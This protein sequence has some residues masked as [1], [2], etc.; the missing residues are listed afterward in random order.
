MTKS[1]R[2]LIQSLLAL[3]VLILLSGLLGY[4]NVVQLQEDTRR[5]E[6]AH[7]VLGSLDRFL[8]ALLDA[9][10]GQRGFLLTGAYPY[11]DPYRT[12][13]GRV[14]AELLLLRGLV[15][16][17]ATQEAG[18]PTLELLVDSRLEEMQK[19]VDLNWLDPG[20]ARRVVDSHAGKNVMDAIRIQLA[21]LTD[22]E[23]ARLAE[24][25]RDFRRGLRVA[26]WSGTFLMLAALALAGGFILQL[27]R[28]LAARARAEQELERERRWLQVTLAS[29]GDAVITTDRA[30]RVSF[31]NPVAET[32]TGWTSGDAAGQPLEAVFHIIDEQ[33]RLPAANPVSRVL[34]EGVTVGLAHH[35]A[36]VQKGGREL[37]IE[38]SAAPIQGLGEETAGV[39]LVFHDVT[40]ARRADAER[41]Q[42]EAQLFQSQRLESLAHLAGGVAHDINNVL[43]AILSLAS[44]RR[45]Q[46]DPAGDLAQALG[47]I[48]T[49][50]VRGRDVVKGLLYFA[51]KGM[52]TRGP[53]DLNALVRQLVR[54]LDATT[55]KQVQLSAELQEPLPL[56]QGDEAALSHALINV[57]MNALDAMP[58]GGALVIGTRAT[59]DGGVEVRV[60]D[61]GGGMSP[62][63]L[64]QAIDPFFTTKPVGK[65]TGLGLSMVYGTMKAHGGTVAIHSEPGRG[66]EVRLGFPAA[67]GLAQVPAGTE[68]AA[69]A[70]ARPLRILLVD[71]D[72]LNRL[73]IPGVLGSLG[74]RVH[75]AAGG[76][77]ALD[78]LAA[79]AEVDLVILD[80]RMPGMDGA[81]TLPRLLALRPGLPVLLATG[82]S[83]R[84][85]QPLLAG[86][87]NVAWIGKPF[88]LEEF[89][90]KLEGLA[91]NVP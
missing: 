60:A 66:T 78:Y 47:T 32:L 53:V 46:L 37:P 77:E 17:D 18:I 57:C 88:T 63:V 21:T 39:V 55:L 52:E 25:E 85:L 19:T 69:A 45:E 33:T 20:A 80:M 29:I 41:R 89:R 28:H 26:V 23:R 87:P 71:D 79:G 86:R 54:L 11:L 9:E 62:E 10:T 64:T 84:D 24:R 65:G 4:R 35:T 50:C 73:A 83:D 76:Q 6:H 72:E 51:H 70:A 13:I 91:V 30:G 7:E 31:L 3:V 67:P 36:L 58:G 59:A 75:A 90:A 56:V 48:V 22:T 5:V 42:L 44:V 82:H 61:T 15:R 43:T 1:I 49:A 12:G 14:R 2:G 40:E 74:H 81:E 68:P 27:R 16:G 34:R 38:D 8:I